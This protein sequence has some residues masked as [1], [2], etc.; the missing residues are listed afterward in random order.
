MFLCAYVCVCVCVDII[1][2]V[3]CPMGLPI[4]NFLGAFQKLQ[5]LFM[6]ESLCVRVYAYIYIYI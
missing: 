2:V 6:Y 5:T 3:V 1:V 4:Q